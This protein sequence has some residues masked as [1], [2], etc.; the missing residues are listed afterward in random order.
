MKV[1]FKKSANK[2]VTRY[3]MLEPGD[4][5]LYLEDFDMDADAHGPIL[6]KLE[7]GHV[8]SPHMT[9]T[10]AQSGNA[11]VIKLDAELV[12]HGVLKE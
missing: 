7:S 3:G 6:I 10:C 5:F 12:V 8:F 11:R 4:V 9:A 1:T 2:A